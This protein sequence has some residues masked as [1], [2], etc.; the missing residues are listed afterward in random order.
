MKKQIFRWAA[1]GLCVIGLS[2]CVVG[3]DDL[4]QGAAENEILTMKPVDQ[5]KTMITVHYEYGFTYN[6]FEELIEN[7]F[8]DVDIVM[9]H[10]GSNSPAFPLRQGLINGV[11]RDLILTRSAPA[12]SDIAPEYLLDLSNQEFVGNYYLTSLDACTNQDG[13]LYYLPGPSDIYGVIYDRTMF[14]KQGWQIPHS[15]SEFVQ[16]IDTINNSGLTAVEKHG[17]EEIVVSYK[18]LQPSIKFPDAFQI[19]FNTFVYDTVYRGA[20]NLQWLVDYRN[21]NSSMI[22]HM[23]PAAEIL[24]RLF[25]DGILSIED[26][27][28]RPYTRSQM[29]Y[30]WHSAAMI[31]ENQNAYMTNMDMS[32]EG[33]WHEVGMLPFW[34]SDNPDSDYLYSIP[35]YYIA[36]NKAAAEESDEKKQLLLD[37]VA[38]LSTPEVQQALVH[39]GIQI[40]NVR[41]VPIVTDNFSEEIID[42]ITEGRIISNFFFF[43]SDD[44]KTVEKMM[45]STVDELVSGTISVEEWLLAADE[46]RDN[47]LGG[48][49]EASEVYGKAERTLTRME[50]ALVVGD[51]Y[52]HVTGAQIA[53]VYAGR[54]ADGVNGFLYE[55]DITEDSLYYISPDRQSDPETSGI[56]IGTLTGQQI[57]DILAGNPDIDEAYQEAHMVTSGLLVEYAPWKKSG[58]HLISCT[59]LDGTP[60]DPQGE[61]QVAYFSGT[62]MNPHA[63]EDEALVISD[64]IILEG[65]W[66]EYF[67]TYLEDLKGE[68]K[69]PEMTT[70]LV[71]ETE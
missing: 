17:G 44:Q 18:A 4:P 26:W 51:M 36:V 69:A 6:E 11:E 34:T 56:A 35:S 52:R 16:L 54:N 22:G 41:G 46:V 23:E 2:G 32:P 28:V 7:Q 37:I 40:S 64:E 67:I 55:G 65:T 30:E 5:N 68:L 33:E 9:V 20:D 31:F 61:Y 70:E 48:V 39:E 27:T 14:E 63:K 62:L 45:H 42:T 25:E 3:K 38:F 43:Y 19:V 12:V 24:L 29:M 15:Y 71:W 60:L 57:M 49:Y 8:P 13:K 21:G 50:A 59:L 1:I 58:E 53:L 10:D 47:Y 66:K